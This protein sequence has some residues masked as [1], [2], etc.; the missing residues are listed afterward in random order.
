MGS[1]AKAIT[2]IAAEPTATPGLQVLLAATPAASF[3]A[4]LTTNVT[5][6]PLGMRL[7]YYVVNHTTTGTIATTGTAPLTGGA[8]TDT[9]YTL[10]LPPQESTGEPIVYVTPVPFASVNASGIALTGLTG[11]LITVYGI[12]AA[13]RLIVGEVKLND[14]VKE[15]SPVEQRGS[16][17]EDFNQLALTQD[18]MW[19]FAADFYADDSFFAY[20]GAYSAA[21]TVTP[22]PAAG[23]AVLASTSVASGS[24]ASAALQP[25]APGMVL[26]IAFGGSAAT[27]AASVSVTGTDRYG[28]TITEVVVPTTKAGGTWTSVNVFASIAV[29]GIVWGAFGAGVT[30]TVTG[31]FGWLI[32]GNPNDLLQSFA[33]EQ[34][35]S[36][37]S[38]CAPFCLVDEWEI[39]GGQEK[40]QK[41]AAKGVAQN[42]YPVGNPATSGNLITQFAQIIDRPYSGWR[43]VVWIDPIANAP[44]T[45]QNAD[46]IDW[47]L[48]IKVNW[49]P[50]HTSWGNPPVRMWNRAYRKRRKLALEV[51]LDMTQATYQQEYVA[52]KQRRLRLVQIQTQG[53][54]IGNVTG[55]NYY[56]GA[57]F[58]MPLKWQEVPERDFSPGQESVILKLKGNLQ[59]WAALGYSHNISWVTR[60]PGAW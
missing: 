1:A 5:N 11:A 7:V 31:Y 19:E 48:N 49:T 30:I 44:G 28:E 46:L 8:Q 3:P 6:A 60:L 34:Y 32:T 42:V 58:I 26:Q 53:E 12:Q 23:V 14:H 18:P 35:D 4:S 51:T 45:T 27:T 15:Y 2:G 57:T 29:N 21:P 50:K 22:L 17:D 52:W 16:F 24:S 13:K 55:T 38:F 54:F 9:S 43:N 25:T 33:M 10:P 59:F 39:T 41:V 56:L 36:T 40:E 47:K 20:L 37:G